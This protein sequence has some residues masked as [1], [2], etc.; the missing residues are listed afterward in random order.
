MPT[1]SHYQDKDNHNILSYS[2]AKDPKPIPEPQLPPP[3]D[4]YS[5][6]Y[7][8]LI[9]HPNLPINPAYISKQP[10]NSYYN[11]SMPPSTE[12]Q[13]KKQKRPVNPIFDPT[14]RLFDCKGNKEKR[15][16]MKQPWKKNIDVEMYV[17]KPK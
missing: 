14:Q 15:V 5:L 2:P 12:T 8:I 9:P 11:S 3:H 13:K 16:K 6:L 10:A 7:S 17:A 4:H 1:E